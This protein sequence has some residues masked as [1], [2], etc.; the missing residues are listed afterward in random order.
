M[1][2][3]TGVTPFT[4]GA[5]ARRVA[6]LTHWKWLQ[7]QTFVGPADAVPGGYPEPDLHASRDSR[8]STCSRCPAQ[9]PRLAQVSTMSKHV[10]TRG[11]GNEKSLQSPQ[12]KAS[13]SAPVPTA[14]SNTFYPISFPTPSDVPRAFPT[15]RSPSLPNPEQHHCQQVGPIHEWMGL[16]IRQTPQEEL[17]GFFRGL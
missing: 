3:G 15:L 11:V 13:N 16:N 8:S 2:T 4:S 5:P 12:E 6:G 17:V 7:R 14:S 10:F 1:Q 9:P